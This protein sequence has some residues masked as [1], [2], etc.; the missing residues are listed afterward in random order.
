MGYIDIMA[1]VAEDFAANQNDVAVCCIRCG[2]PNSSGTAALGVT[3][4][5]A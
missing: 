3:A 4:A 5:S 2:P 1:I